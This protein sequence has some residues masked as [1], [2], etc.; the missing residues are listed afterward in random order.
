[1]FT[2]TRPLHPRR[3][4]PA[5]PRCRGGVSSV[6][7]LASANTSAPSSWFAPLLGSRSGTRR[8]DS[9]SSEPEAVLDGSIIT[10]LLPS[11]ELAGR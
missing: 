5:G 4:R 8:T 6:L 3:S 1:M 7:R 10:R 9:S 2:V 11:H